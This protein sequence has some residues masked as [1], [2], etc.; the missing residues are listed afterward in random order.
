MTTNLEP[1]ARP[2][3]REGMVWMLIAIPLA[4][5]IMGLITL[6]LAVS[7]DDGLVTDDYYR[8]GLAI[9]KDLERDRA[10]VLYQMS[11]LLE[12]D[13]EHN[14]LRV[15]LRSG[16]SIPLPDD[17]SVD[18]YHATRQGFDR[19]MLLQKQGAGE[20]RA[21]L[22]DMV[23]GRWYVQLSAENWRLNGSVLFPDAVRVE[24]NGSA[25]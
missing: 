22:P 17:L 3:Y 15:G 1:P 4:A 5:V 21:V 20:Y 2:W 18:L 25:P 23:P 12:L 14:T 16:Q 13:Q 11:A 19:S 6:G 8:R 10:A 9:N 7:T 24:L